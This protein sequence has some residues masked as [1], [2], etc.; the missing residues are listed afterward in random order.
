MRVNKHGTWSNITV[1]KHK[2]R[3][4]HKVW[5]KDM[6]HKDVNTVRVNKHETGAKHLQW[7]LTN[8]NHKH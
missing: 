4:K 3:S 8:M 1:K 2:S 7:E 5:V 6:E